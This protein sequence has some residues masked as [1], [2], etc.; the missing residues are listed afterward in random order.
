MKKNRSLLPVARRLHKIGHRCSPFVTCNAGPE[1]DRFTIVL[2]FKTTDDIHDFYR[3]FI[4]FFATN[5]PVNK[6]LKR[7]PPRVGAI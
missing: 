3:A 1:P 7:K 2:K 5:K 4:E 6:A